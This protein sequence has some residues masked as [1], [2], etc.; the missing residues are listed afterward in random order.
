MSRLARP[1]VRTPGGARP[2][3]SDHMVTFAQIEQLK[4]QTYGAMAQLAGWKVVVTFHMDSGQSM[5][6]IINSRGEAVPIGNIREM[7]RAERDIRSLV[8]R[9]QVTDDKELVDLTVRTICTLANQ[10]IDIP[11][12]YRET[13]T[14]LAKL[15]AARSLVKHCFR[16]RAEPN[17]C[18]VLFSE[19]LREQLSLAENAVKDHVQELGRG[20]KS[21]L[22]TKY[23]EQHVCGWFIRNFLGDNP[24]TMDGKTQL[25]E[26]MYLK[27]IFHL[28]G[29]EMEYWGDRLPP[30]DLIRVA[31]PVDI[32]IDD[33]EAADCGEKVA[34]A[35][36]RHALNAQIPVYLVDF[37]RVGTLSTSVGRIAKLTNVQNKLPEPIG[38][39]LKAY[40][41]Y[42]LS[43]LFTGRATA[44]PMEHQIFAKRVG[45]IAE[46]D[47]LLVQNFSACLKAKPDVVLTYTTMK[48][49]EDRE[50]PGSDRFGR[51]VMRAI[52]SSNPRTVAYRTDLAKAKYKE[53][54]DHVDI[55]PQ[56]QGQRNPDLRIP[57]TIFKNHPHPADVERRIKDAIVDNFKATKSNLNF[58]SPVAKQVLTAGNASSDVKRIVASVPNYDLQQILANRALFMAPNEQFAGE[59]PDNDHL[60]ENPI[61]EAF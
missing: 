31:L 29:A 14:A 27:E 16:L 50:S 20:N 2:D 52:A 10:A 40:Q 56:Y 30:S 51:L 32:L 37:R 59:E 49:W 8:R 44:F 18:D 53:M 33:E 34:P 39:R 47:P 46:T 11:A 43:Q 17:T 41:T 21:D 1:Q 58:L 24:I 12:V 54:L 26:V 3:A 38:G 35:L 23:A 60:D 55:H 48:D 15:E 25:I 28:T 19:F 13:K 22:R 4:L 6:Q 7:L 9:N 45:E 42:I 5:A 57:E 61:G 36:Q